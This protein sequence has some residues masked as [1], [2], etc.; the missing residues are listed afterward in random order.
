MWVSSS[1]PATAACSV[2]PKAKSTVERREPEPD[3]ELAVRRPAELE[4][5]LG[6]IGDLLVEQRE[7]VGAHRGG[8]RR[9]AGDRPAAAAIAA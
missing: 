9:V 2:S 6:E 7:L 4:D 8:E 1:S 5:P 3:R